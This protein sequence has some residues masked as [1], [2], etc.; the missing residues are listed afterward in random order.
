MVVVFHWIEF[1]DPGDKKTYRSR[2]AGLVPQIDRQAQIRELLRSD[3]S[4]VPW[5]MHKYMLYSLPYTILYA[6]HI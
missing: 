2:K 6:L 4:F 3:Q 1:T 5:H